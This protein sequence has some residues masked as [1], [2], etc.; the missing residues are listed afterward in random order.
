MPSTSTKQKRF[1]AAVAHNPEFAKKA[2]VPVSVGKEF[3][4]ADMAQKGKT[5]ATKG[6]MMPFMGKE[7]KAEEAKEMKS[8]KKYAAGGSV[9][10]FRRSAD[11][12]ASKGKTK[13]KQVKMAHGGSCK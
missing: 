9:G 3:V 2:G 4:R 10:G 11:G 8:G 1:M 12:I 7:T 5:M 13:A 6:K